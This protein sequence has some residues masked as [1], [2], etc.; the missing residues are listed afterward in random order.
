MKKKILTSSI[1]LTAGLFCVM[2]IE[3]SASAVKKEEKT[4]EEELAPRSPLNLNQEM[5]LSDTR[6]VIHANMIAS[7]KVMDNIRLYLTDG[8]LLTGY[9]KEITSE[10]SSIDNSRIFRVY[11]EMNNKENTGFGFVLSTNDIFAGA[12]VFRNSGET[13]TVVYNDTIGGYILNKK[14]DKSF[15]PSG[16]KKEKKELTPVVLI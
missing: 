12:V 4:K 6:G 14:I 5:H 9:V 3:S 15:K 16:L 2:S 13:Y 11:G 10:I 1:L 7:L 8:T